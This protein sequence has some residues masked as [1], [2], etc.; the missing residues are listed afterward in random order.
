MSGGG[1]MRLGMYLFHCSPEINWLVFFSVP[2]KR[3]FSLMFPYCLCFL[4]PSKV[5]ICSIVPLN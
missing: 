4:F 1:G 2:L 5:A 3:F